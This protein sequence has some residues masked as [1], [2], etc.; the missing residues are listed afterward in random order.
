MTNNWLG[1]W[2][3]SLVFLGPGPP[4]HYLLDFFTVAL[5]STPWL[6]FINSQLVCLLPVGILNQFMFISNVCFLFV[7]IGLKNPLQIVVN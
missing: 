7:C 1:H 6:H 5:S 2:A 4:P 3:C